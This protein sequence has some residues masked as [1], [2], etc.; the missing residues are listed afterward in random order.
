M[1]VR[2]E[3]NVQLV[4]RSRVVA[5]L[6]L[7]M[8]ALIFGSSLALAPEAQALGATTT[9]TVVRGDVLVRHADGEF[10]PAR[11]GEVIAAGDTIRTGSD[12]LAEITYFEG[13]SV[14]IESRTEL[15]I[16]ALS[17]ESDGGT[18]I[19][20]WQTVGRTWHVVTKLITGS[21]RYEVRTPSS[22][23]SVRGT[24]FA[25][26]VRLEPAGSLAT[27]TTSEGAVVHIGPDPLDQ[28]ATTAVRVNAGQRSTKSRGT[29]AE[30]VRTASTVSFGDA[31]KRAAPAARSTT[32]RAVSVERATAKVELRAV[33]R[34]RGDLRLVVD[35]D[36]TRTASGPRARPSR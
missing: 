8:A 16:E 3:A 4:S 13:S 28:N 21:S 15:V 31:P 35:R 1:E 32:S 6:A 24:I 18:V 5:S 14:R 33:E 7:A 11:D 29:V 23:A 10:V 25:V 26:D 19:A 20:M 17:T 36:R 22:T 30:P 34:D 27:V 12:A 2:G 9:L